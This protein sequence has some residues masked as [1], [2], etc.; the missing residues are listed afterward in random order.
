MP[1]N[2]P[3]LAQAASRTL[4][5][6]GRVQSPADL[7]APVLATAVV[8]TL[9]VYLY[10]RDG[11]ELS[12]AVRWLLTVLR[13]AAFLALLAIY[14]QPQWRNEIDQ[15]QNSRVVLLAD[16]S[17]SMGLHD[18]EA[19][20]VPAEPSRAQ[21]VAAALGR[22]DWLDR[23]RR[24]HD[25]VL[26]RFDQDAPRVLSLD[27]R[28]GGQPVIQPPSAGSSATDDE[29][30]D[31]EEALAPRGAETRLGQALRQWIDAERSSPLSGIVVFTDGQHNAGLDP[32]VAIAQAREARV[33]IYT[34]GIGSLTQP[35][36]VRISDLQA[37]P[38]AYPGDRYTVTG[39]LQ[40]QGLAGKAVTV[41]LESRDAAGPAAA[42][43][44]L[45]GTQEVTLGGD[46][47]VVPARFELT[48]AEA[49]RRTLRLR[50]RPPAAD[51]NPSDNQQ[52]ADVEIV[53]RKTRV[54]LFAGGPTRE[55]QFLRNQLRRDREVVVDVLLQSGASG[56]SQDA[57]EILDAF[58]NTPEALFEYDALVAFDPDWR[59]LT[60]AQQELVERWASDQAGGMIVI[61]GPVFTDHWAQDASLSK[62]RGLYPVEFHRRLTLL[63]DS[64]HEA[65]EPWPIEFSR[66][67]LE[68]EFLWIEDSLTASV[69]AWA[70]FPG[71]YGHYS[72]RGP[73]P[74]A[75]VYGYF[76][77]PRAAE[78]GQKPV[79]L[80]GQF[81]GAGRVFYLGSGEMWRLR[82]IDDAYFE[83]FYTKLIRHVS[84]GRLLRGSQRGVLLVERD[85]YFLG[86]TV[87]V[88]AQLT[89]SRLAPLDLPRVPL[90]ITLPDTTRQ[91]IQ[92]LADPTKKGGYRGQFTARK[93]GTYL[94]ELSPPDGDE[95][96]SRR[97]QVKM[98]EREREHP[99][100]NDALLSEIARQTG[101]V[102]YV[103]L[104]AAVAETPGS[105]GAKPL[106][107]V[108][109]DASRT[110][111]TISLPTPLWS[112]AWTMCTVCGLLCLEWL[113]RRLAKLA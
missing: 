9:V 32:A 97:V 25:V 76:S 23:L 111:T 17:I 42:E 78:A 22:G 11:V 19:T 54:L 105:T 31:F 68:A 88:R 113:I 44:K 46:G 89:D 30:L 7:L 82:A 108:L 6:W 41:E 72:V 93:E 91:T 79:Y 56:I 14:L 102:Y 99:E 92:L 62:I 21:R 3:L 64:R 28:A 40:A 47:E 106:L 96:I 34:V 75:T 74:A 35:V 18:A 26:A 51:R 27:K 52:E 4:F 110:V 53:D 85:R 49:G 20:P 71:V 70:D 12:A 69:Q 60:S 48:P 13:M 86:G 104:E 81:F 24:K 103:G 57:H 87:D 36:N 98:P 66:D 63:G 80:A 8:L 109:R 55:Y 58:P 10:R 39:F 15:V 2:G 33:P 50:V 1:T 43:A 73:K 61:A 37:P 94:L 84:Q 100:R 5:E 90:E 38:R 59:Q 83:R 45:E 95:L 67:G 29:K 112:N 107:A 65:D 101:G 16:T 77:D